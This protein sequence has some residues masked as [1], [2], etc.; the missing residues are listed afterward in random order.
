MQS[1][2]ILP[3][4]IILLLIPSASSAEK[5]TGN[6]RLVGYTKYRDAVFMDTARLS[7]SPNG[8]STA[9]IKI[10]PSGKSKYRRLIN[11]YLVLV[12]QQSPAFK[13]IEI[14]YDIHCRDQLIRF[15]KFVYLDTDGNMIYEASENRPQ[16]L[17]ISHGSVWHPLWKT[18]CASG[19]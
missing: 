16:W 19:P 18:S 5:M 4:L 2:N 13:S 12:T 10:A 8:I 3:F 11:E 14:L 15:K 6:W 17:R 1:M 7:S 9:W